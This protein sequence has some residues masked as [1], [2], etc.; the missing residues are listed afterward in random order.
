MGS[1]VML[2][3]FNQG[4]YVVLQSFNSVCVMALGHSKLKVNVLISARITEKSRT[5]FSIHTTAHAQVRDVTLDV[6][7]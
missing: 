1:L 2:Q 5:V 6:E 7:L 4:L 3:N